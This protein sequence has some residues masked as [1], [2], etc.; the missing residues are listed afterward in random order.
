MEKEKILAAARSEKH[1]GKEYENKQATRGNLLSSFLALIVGVGLFCAEYI[2]K[3]TLNFGLVAVGMT[4]VAVQY[5][6]EG[7]TVK[8]GYMI[9]LGIICSLVAAFFALAFIGQVVAV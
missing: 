4:A 2:I 5:L 3:E 9:V 6:Y 8:K 7:V 1:R